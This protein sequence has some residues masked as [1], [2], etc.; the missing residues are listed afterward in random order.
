MEIASCTFFSLCTNC[1][2]ADVYLENIKIIRSEVAKMREAS[3]RQYNLLD[4]TEE[5]LITNSRL[6]ASM[7]NS[8]DVEK[9][10]VSLQEEQQINDMDDVDREWNLLIQF[11][12]LDFV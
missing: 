7:G 12:R 6:M 9:N 8:L 5:M 2:S 3:M 11:Y 1:W 10:P 4:A